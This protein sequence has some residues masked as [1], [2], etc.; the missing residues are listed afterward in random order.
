VIK[1]RFI[2]VHTELAT[3][4]THWATHLVAAGINPRAMGKCN[5]SI[6][7]VEVVI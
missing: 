5:R 2:S 7:S 1:S 3:S 4:T 6:A